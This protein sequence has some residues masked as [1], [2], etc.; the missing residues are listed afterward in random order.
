MASRRRNLA[1]PRRLDCGDVDLSHVHHSFK[2]ALCFIAAGRHRFCQYARRDLPRH[3]PFVF[4][5]AARAFLAAII[6]DGVPIPIRLSLI[7]SG[8]LERKGFIMFERRTA[9]EADT[10]D[11]SNFELDCQN[12]S[13]LA[14]GIVTGCTVDGAHRTVGKSFGIKSSS[15]LGIFIVPE[16]NCILCHC[17]SF[18]SEAPD[19]LS[20]YS[21]IG[22]QSLF[23]TGKNSAKAFTASL[24][25]FGAVISG[26]F[27]KL[28][29]KSAL[30]AKAGG[31]R[32]ALKPSPVYDLN[33]VA[34]GFV[35]LL[36]VEF[37]MQP[38]KAFVLEAH[39][40]R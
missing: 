10:G 28:R 2:R 12:I 38:P 33:P 37:S 24:S 4:A 14:R 25:A 23:S 8:D 1:V 11:A 29:A 6:D 31:L 39:G 22:G 32:R 16:A 13:L 7:V 36:A 3:A 34:L 19:L 15:G 26:H 35:P 21:K 9:V 18:R 27:A 20:T 30:P 40:A 5:P 17:M